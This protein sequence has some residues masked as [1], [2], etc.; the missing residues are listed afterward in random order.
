MKLI[1]LAKI[2]FAGNAGAAPGP[3]LAA[4]KDVILYD[5]DGSEVASYS[6]EEFAALTE[7][8]TPPAHEGLTFQEWNWPLADAQAYCAQYGMMDI[9]ATYITSDGKSRIYITLPEGRISPSLGLAINGTVTIDWGDESQ[10]NTVIG[11]SLSTLINTPHT[12]PSA[13]SYL[14]TITPSAG[15][16]IKLMGQSNY[17]SCL[18][19]AEKTSKNSQN[20]VYQNSIKRVEL[21]LGAKIGSYAFMQCTNLALVN[22]P[23]DSID[24]IEFSAFSSTFKLRS[25]VV[26]RGVTVIENSAFY[27]SNISSLALSPNITVIQQLACSRTRVKRLCLPPLLT[28]IN[29]DLASGCSMLENVIIPDGVTRILSSAFNDCNHLK[30]IKIPDGVYSIASSA[31]RNCTSLKS[32]DIPNVGAITTNVFN[33]C[34]GLE[35]VHIADGVTQIADYAFASCSNLREINIPAGLNSI[36]TYAFENC[37]QLPSLVIPQGVTRLNNSICSNCQTLVE[38]IIS[39]NVT[40]L[41]VNCFRNCYCLPSITIP[42]MVT[43][44][45]SQCFQNCYSLGYIYVSNATPPAIQSNTFDKIPDDVIIYVPAESVEAYKAA[46]NW[47]AH[48]S[49]I[50]PM[51]TT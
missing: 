19:W 37:M 28:E 6:A 11:T 35:T 8:P 15:S 34:T 4:E 20:K 23:K 40:Q 5:Y 1:N 51:P 42:S 9:G 48:A 25:L 38:V 45:G 33:G 46:T 50:Q 12:Y 24:T 44:I 43:T 30:S 14:I 36:A 39:E 27:N 32:I 16:T 2:D 10:Q 22:I 47:S 26:P 49:K 31:F 3:A 13:G 29:T 18:L 21:G 7:L 17:D 41:G